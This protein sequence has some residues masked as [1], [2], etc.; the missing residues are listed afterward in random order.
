MYK[1]SGKVQI[2]GRIAY[3][4]QQAW[5]VNMTLQ[6]NI[7]FGN[8]YDEARYKQAI[9]A[10]GLESDIAILPA[11]DMTEI[12]ERGINLSGGQKQRV[13]LARAAYANADIYLLDDPLSAVDAHVDKHL[14]EN[15][16]GP[17]GM[18]RDKTRVLVTHGIHHLREMN[19]IVV[20]KDGVVEEIGG[21]SE[22][23]ATKGVFYRL[24][25][26]YA[27]QE[28]AKSKFETKVNKGH[29]QEEDAGVSASNSGTLTPV[30]SQDG[31]DI[32]LE[33]DDTD[34]QNT[35]E[36]V[37]EDTITRSGP[38]DEKIGLKARLTTVETLRQGAIEWNVAVA[39]ARAASLRTGM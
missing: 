2:S 7:L 6:E 3:V 33:Q 9:H 39:Y 28:R 13:S 36:T 22:L 32:N 16:L 14:W 29:N 8:E 21:Y 18:L 5:I 38:K 35:S 11:G 34:G 4:P 23:M 26:E 19:Q 24:I 25:K 10:S 17:K 31:E 27:I 37:T 1:L 15:I 12:G 30:G 20:L